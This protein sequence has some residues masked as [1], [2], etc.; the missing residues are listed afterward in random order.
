MGLALILGYINTRLLL[1]IIF[2]LFLTPIAW[3]SRFFT[4]DKLQLTKKNGPRESYFRDRDHL[5]QAEDFE[6]PW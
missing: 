3:L 6:Q 5:Y 1:G 2:F 4:R